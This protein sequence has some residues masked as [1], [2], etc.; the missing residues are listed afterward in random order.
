MGQ[1]TDPKTSRLLNP[2]Q[3]P[4]LSD[5]LALNYASSVATILRDKFN[6]TRIA[7][8]VASTVQVTLAALAGAG[9]AFDFGATAVA[10]LALG[11]AGIPELQK[12]F[13]AKGCTE[14]FQDAVR[15]PKNFGPRIG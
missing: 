4:I 14:V 10:G 2:A 11:S 5:G 13:D 12:I 7:N 8:E 3:A 6:G 15:G 1:T 9:A